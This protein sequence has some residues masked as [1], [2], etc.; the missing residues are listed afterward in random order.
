LAALIAL[1][2]PLVNLSITVIIEAVT[3]LKLRR[4][5]RLTDQL[6]AQAAG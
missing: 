3:A 4:A 5:Q 1:R 2:V 6:S